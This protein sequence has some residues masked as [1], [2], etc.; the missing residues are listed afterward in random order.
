V[1]ESRLTSADVDRAIASIHYTVLPD[2]F[3]TVCTMF[4]DNGE[5]VHG[6]GHCTVPAAEHPDLSR[7]SAFSDAKRQVWSLLNFRRADQM[8]SARGKTAR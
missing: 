4:M 5:V 3:T 2:G 6:M 8:M 1:T 7:P